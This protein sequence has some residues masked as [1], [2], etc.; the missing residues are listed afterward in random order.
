M[1]CVLVLQLTLFTTKMN[2]NFKYDVKCMHV[3]LY[4]LSCNKYNLK[5]LPRI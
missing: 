1:A 4:I 5:W 3:C 2:Y